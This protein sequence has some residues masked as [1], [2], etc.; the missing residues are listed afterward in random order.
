[1]NEINLPLYAIV[2]LLIRVSNLYGNIGDYHDHI[3]QSDYAV[4]KTSKG[5]I[6]FSKAIITKQFMYPEKI[7]NNE[8][9][10]ALKTFI[11]N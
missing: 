7:S 1:M 10:K 6:R 11:P 4:I 3:S 5:T 8:L 2:E 9:L